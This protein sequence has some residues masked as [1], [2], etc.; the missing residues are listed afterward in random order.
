MFFIILIGYQIFSPCNLLIFC[1]HHKSI[2]A[3]TYVPIEIVRIGQNI[4]DSIHKLML[5]FIDIEKNRFIYLN[6]QRKD[7]LK[8]V[9]ICY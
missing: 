8:I 3:A 4:I 5:T 9:N 2:F 1:Q 7:I 6:I